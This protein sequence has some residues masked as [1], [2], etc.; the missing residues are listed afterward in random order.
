MTPRLEAFRA[1]GWMLLASALWGAAFVAQSHAA[2]HLDAASIVAIR[3]LAGG[4]LLV[5]VVIVRRKSV[6]QRSPIGV[7]MRGGIGAGVA[8]LIAAIL[9]QCGIEQGCTASAAGFITGLYVLFVPI[10]GLIGGM[11]THLSVWSG[12]VV[13]AIGLYLLSVAPTLS[14]SPGDSLVL[15]CAV[16]WAIH[17]LVIGRFSPRCDAIELAATQ[18]LTTGFLALLMMD[19]VP[20]PEAIQAAMWPMLYLGPVAVS[21]A[22]TLQVVGQRVAPPAHAAVI[23]SMEGLFAAVFGAILAGERLGAGQYVGCGFMLAGALLAQWTELRR[24]SNPGETC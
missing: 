13:A 8:M 21:I 15:L 12:A 7:V 9:Q 23:L 18:F 19:R 14:M 3:F 22:F 11:R 17:V 24:R 6:R 4:L 1:D 5:P 20:S 2:A 16:A 10:L